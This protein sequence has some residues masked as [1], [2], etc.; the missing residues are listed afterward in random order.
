MAVEQN[1]E[2][3]EE[4]GEECIIC[5]SELPNCPLD[6]WDV[7]ALPASLS[8]SPNGIYVATLPCRHYFHNQCLESWCQVANTCPLCRIEFFKVDVYEYVGGPW[9]RAY[10]VEEKVQAVANAEAPPEFIETDD[11]T[12]CVICGGSQQQDVL[13]LCD[14]CD[15]AYH[16]F[17]LELD[18]VP[19]NEFYCPNC[20]FLNNDN[21]NTLA[22]RIS[23]SHRRRTNG[24]AARASRVSQRQQRAW[25]RAW[26]AIRNRAWETLNSDLSYYSL[27]GDIPRRD[28]ASDLLRRR[29]ENARLRSD[30]NVNDEQQ[31]QPPFVQTPVTNDSER[32]AWNDFDVMLHNNEDHSNTGDRSNHK[33][34][35]PAERS[36]AADTN[37]R[38]KLKKPVHRNRS[39]SISTAL[40]S[41]SNQS[42]TND[43][44]HKPSLLANLIDNINRPSPSSQTDS[45][46]LSKVQSI[47]KRSQEG[48]SS[49][50]SNEP[51]LTPLFS[52][53]SPQSSPPP[54]LESSS[55]ISSH[56]DGPSQPTEPGEILD[57]DYSQTSIDRRTVPRSSGR[58]E[59]TKSTKLPYEVKY[60]IERLVNAALK[61]YYRDAKITKEQFA[62]FNKNISRS[63][64][65]LFLDGSLSFERSGQY[66]IANEI[67][68]R[69]DSCMRSNGESC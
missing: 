20:V 63:L 54:R 49:N 65:T 16:T 53:L 17:C 13:L 38:K 39:I 40:G 36:S 37:Q 59:L 62:K 6:K 32:K 23:L 55:P 10:P 61:P 2:N 33:A 21:V 22:S 18:E 58:R 25:T 42:T 34:S 11:M 3:S 67:R 7:S 50:N 45:Q 68:E 44:A 56:F 46:F 64:Y 19:E 29:I 48:T 5:L 41:S 15:D 27:D 66:Q 9:L 28:H 12:R 69:V 26:N 24:R 30:S 31:Q 1:Q 43:E 51:H 60:R 57:N 4:N 47:L 8:T 35:T 14:G 52:N